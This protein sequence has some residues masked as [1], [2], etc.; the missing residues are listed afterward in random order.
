[1][2][3]KPDN[4]SWA[5]WHA[6]QA[7]RNRVENIKS[8]T[9]YLTDKNCEICWFGKPLVCALMIETLNGKISADICRGC[10]ERISAAIDARI[11]DRRLSNN[12]K[13][14]A[15]RHAKGRA[16]PAKSS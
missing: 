3:D 16:K 10:A 1:M 8:R 13:F 9:A 15:Y 6:V 11:E 12:R 14:G 4:L 2:S 7:R 5:Q